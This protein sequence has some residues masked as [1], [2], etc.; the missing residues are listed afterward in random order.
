MH[1]KA[2]WAGLI[3]RTCQNQ[4]FPPP[5]TAKQRVIIIPGNQSEE[6][7]DGY[8]RKDHIVGQACVVMFNE[9]TFLSTFA[10]FQTFCFIIF[11]RNTFNTFK[12][13][14]KMQIYSKSVLNWFLLLTKFSPLVNLLTYII[15][16]LFKLTIILVPLMLSHLLVH[17]PPRPLRSQIA[18]FSMPRLIA[19][20]N[21]LFDLVN[22]FHLFI[23]ISIH[24]S[25][26]PSSLHSFTLNSK[27]TFSV[28]P[29]IPP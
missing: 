6:G 15:S 12:W 3:C 7:I 28:N 1:A 27:L 2:S 4:L 13:A 14:T 20:I 16:S 5:V 24:P 21:F 17:L 23:R 11:V 9:I 18:L 22:Q 29:L 8:G 10:H 26:H 19:G 25:L